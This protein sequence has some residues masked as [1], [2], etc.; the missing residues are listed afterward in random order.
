MTPV[1]SRRWRWL[2][3][4]AL[5]MLGGGA[6]VWW[7][8]RAPV[9]VPPPLPANLTD[10]EVSQALQ[11]ARQKVVDNPR[12]ALAWGQLGMTLEAHLYE[13]EADRCFAEAARLNPNDPRWPYFRGLHALKYDPDNA[14]AFLRQAADHALPGSASALRLRLAE[15]LLERQQLDEAE[16]LFRE[17]WQRESGQPRT[18][19]GLG[20]I[21]L[22]RND[23]RAAE[24]FL[25]VA[26]ASPTA[27]RP[28]TAHLA[29]LA[30]ARGDKAAASRYERDVGPRSGDAL[31]W[32]DP[33]VDEILALQVGLDTRLKGVS[34]LERQHRYDE[35]AQAYLDQLKN[36]PSTRAYVGAGLNLVRLGNYDQGLPLLREAV[37]LDP[38][39]SNPHYTLAQALFMRAEKQW[40]QTPDA[41]EAKEWLREVIVEARRTTELKRDHAWAYLFWGLS[42]R[43]LG[44]PAA[45]LVP[46]RQGV[47]CRPGEIELQLALG[48]TLLEVG[49]L[50]EAETHL[51]NARQLDPKDQRPA[52]AL[53]RLRSRKE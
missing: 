50:R 40:A 11:Q 42:L 25:T 27:R 37:K 20:L 7:W 9:A 41:P 4:A 48:E 26:R 14:V 49:E 34:E 8:F 10:P 18:A 24:E 45:A 35:A 30:H 52:R 22:A 16:K 21:A 47:A 5:L 36:H 3:V 6:G 31:A 33:L 17:E 38:E 46:L 32:P 51:E 15:A 12:S 39:S 44:E 1:V 19:F 23:A 13:P 2:L 43:Y 28:A 29:A 53:E